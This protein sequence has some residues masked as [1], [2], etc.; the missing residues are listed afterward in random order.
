MPGLYLDSS[1]VV[2]LVVA[3]PES[4]ALFDFVAGQPERVSSALTRVEVHRALRRLGANVT[5]RRRAD[6]VLS[7]LSLVRID[8]TIVQVASELTPPDLRSLDAIHLAT[9]L[10]LGDGIE[11]V[12]TYDDRLAR[13]ATKLRLKVLRPA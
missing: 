6:R 12:V 10:A 9:A 7:H 3:E 2:K 4:P 8:E 11:G 5:E 13:A 1:A